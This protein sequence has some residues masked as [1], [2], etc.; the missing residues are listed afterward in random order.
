MCQDGESRESTKPSY[1]PS[2]QVPDKYKHAQE[3]LYILIQD[4]V[5]SMNLV[6][7]I[8]RDLR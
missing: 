4:S 1:I 3:V 8:D 6:L 5:L 2:E 7:N